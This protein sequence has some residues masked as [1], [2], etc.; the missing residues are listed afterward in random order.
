M[1]P[2]WSVR[3]RGGIVSLCITQ[4]EV[5]QEFD[6]WKSSRPQWFKARLVNAMRRVA[7]QYEERK[8]KR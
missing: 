8:E 6:L 7:A 5:C 1:A 2:K 3:I 4:G